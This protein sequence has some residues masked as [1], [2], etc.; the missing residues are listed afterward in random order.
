MTDIDSATSF[1][2]AL[3]ILSFVLLYAS[4]YFSTESGLLRIAELKK[5]SSSLSIQLFET[6]DSSLIETGRKIQILF[7]ENLGTDHQ[8]TL[9][10]TIEPVI[11]NIHV[12]D[13]FLNE[14]PSTINISQG[15]TI[16]TFNLTFES[17]EEKRID[18]IY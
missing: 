8:E 4:N 15:K 3:T 2:L 12:Y 7:K 9:Q 16:V 14:I 17:D 6:F 11:P 1:V 13:K 5:S 18:M 10:V